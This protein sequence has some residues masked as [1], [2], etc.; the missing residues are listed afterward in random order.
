[1]MFTRRIGNAVVTN[2]IEYSGPTHDPAVV[3]PALA[4]GDLARAA[5]PLA[6]HHYVPAMNRFIVTIQIW[7]VHLGADVIVID[8]GV[9]NFKARAAARMNMLNTLVMPWLEAA[10]AGPDRVTHVVNTHLHADHVGWNTR[11]VDGRWEPAFPKARYV[12]PR[13]DFALFNA[14][15]QDG[16]RQAAAGSFADSVLPVVEAGLAQFVDSDGEVAGL[17]IEPLPGHTPGQFGL[18]LRSNG[19]EGMFCAD[20]MHS[21][22]QIAL[23]DL[24][25]AFCMDAER[26]R[27]TRRAFLPRMAERRALIMPCHF[28]APYCGTVE[29][30]PDGD[31]GF[32]PEDNSE[33]KSAPP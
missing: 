10:G 29:K 6:P 30:R 31:I 2:V 1:M 5:P 7:V 28:G 14:Q 24:N 22:I 27:Q 4:P 13:A 9:G 17:T 32:M 20:V 3:F 23:P 19:Q 18:R 25:T 33:D 12:M 8:T 16:N 21:P 11:L 26:A 15:Y